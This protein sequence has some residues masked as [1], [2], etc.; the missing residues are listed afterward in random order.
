MIP[1]IEQKNGYSISLLYLCVHSLVNRSIFFLKFFTLV[2]LFTF[3]TISF[4]STSPS[5]STFSLVV[6]PLSLHFSLYFLNF[7]SLLF[8]L[9]SLQF[10]TLVTFSNFLVQILA[11]LII[12]FS[13]FT[14]LVYFIILVY[15]STF[16]LLFLA[17]FLLQLCILITLSTFLLLFLTRFSLT[18]LSNFS[19]SLFLQFSLQLSHFLT[20]SL[21]PRQR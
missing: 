11:L 21:F 12:S 7:V 5:Q 20:S 14:Y 17:Y 18:V 2:S 10:L 16:S 3:F 13:L 4:E 8:N 9:L 6:H 19:L 15:Q 1:F